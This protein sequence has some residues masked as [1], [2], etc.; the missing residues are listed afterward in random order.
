MATPFAAAFDPA[1]VAVVTGGAA[2][3]R[4]FSEL[5]FDRLVFTGST[6]VA[7]HV[8]AAA[9]HLMPLAL[10]LGGKSPTNVGR[11]ADVVRATDRSAT[12]KMINAGQICLAPDYLLVRARRRRRLS[13]D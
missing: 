6:A 7:R 13:P 8:M 10:E 11:S 5:P 4:A 1:E 12:G 3:G 9:A 2:A